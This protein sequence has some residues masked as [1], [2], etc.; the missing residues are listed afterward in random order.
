MAALTKGGDHSL[1]LSLMG[2]DEQS[3]EALVEAC[4][5]G[6]GRTPPLLPAQFT[7]ALATK[8]FSN[9]DADRPLVAALY[10]QAFHTAFRNVHVLQYRNLGWGDVEAAQLASVLSEVAQPLQASSKFTRASRATPLNELYL[11]GNS[12]GDAGGTALVSAAA[13]VHGITWFNMSDN[14]ALGD[15]TLK[16]L[17]K[18]LGESK[19][20]FKRLKEVRLEGCGGGAAAKAALEKAAKARGVAVKL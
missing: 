19:S 4:A 15:E 17:A 7:D 12:I 13:A 1:D 3:R 8:R 2:G 16:L 20:N 5:R 9:P 14:A 11:S 6:G 18:L 10:E